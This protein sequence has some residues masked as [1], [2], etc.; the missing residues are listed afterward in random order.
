MK[1]KIAVRW[2]AALRSDK[3]KQTTA[4]LHNKDGYCCL[5]VL[6]ELAVASGVIPKPE[7]DQDGV[8]EYGSSGIQQ[9]LPVEVMD[10]A[11]IDTT[12]GEFKDGDNSNQELVALN[13]DGHSFKEIA[14]II[15]AN[16]SA[17]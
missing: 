12:T 11:G 10:W 1:K 17:L 5:G 7:E 2:V 15:E 9:T 13:D 14:D 3:F 6:C 8:F 16:V 4:Y